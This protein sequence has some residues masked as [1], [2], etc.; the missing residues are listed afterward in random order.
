MCWMLRMIVG[1][2]VATGL[3]QRKRYAYMIDHLR[4]HLQSWPDSATCAGSGLGL[5]GINVYISTRP[6]Q[7]EKHDFVTLTG[8]VILFIV[9]SPQALIPPPFNLFGVL[10]A[11]VI[12]GSLFTFLEFLFSKSRVVV[13]LIEAF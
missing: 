4:Q 9:R 6:S 8:I 13:T 12:V 7:N 11:R 1:Q 3:H 5:F 10:D 2:R